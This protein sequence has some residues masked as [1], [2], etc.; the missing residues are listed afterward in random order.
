MPNAP[1]CLLCDTEHALSE[2]C[3]PGGLGRQMARLGARRWN[4]LA[5]QQIAAGM[6]RA[7][8]GRAAAR[9][10]LTAGAGP[11]EPINPA[12]SPQCS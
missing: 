10:R 3:D 1:H 7:L 6:S 9:N 8:S 2:P 5:D 4:R 11:A 12:T